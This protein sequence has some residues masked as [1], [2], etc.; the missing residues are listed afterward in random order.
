LV[1]QFDA[2][3]LD[4]FAE[5]MRCAVGLL[6]LIAITSGPCFLPDTDE[7]TIRI[8]EPPPLVTARPLSSPVMESKWVFDN[9]RLLHQAALSPARA[10]VGDDRGGCGG[11]VAFSGSEPASARESR[12]P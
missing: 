9:R 1:E 11:M 7:D 3:R 6:A 5:T 2:E 10:R 12:C 4:P 8:P